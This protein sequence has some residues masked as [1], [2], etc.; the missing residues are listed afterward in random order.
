MK[1]IILYT[2]VEGQTRKIA[3][4]A[5]DFFEGRGWYVSIANVMDMLEFGLE[6]PDAAILLAPV[7]LARY[8]TPFSH[9]VHQEKD[10]LNSIPTAFVSVSLSIVSE[11]KDERDEAIG[12]PATLLEQTGWAPV[13]VHNAAGALRLAEF[14]FFKRWMVRRLSKNTASCC[15]TDGDR[16]FTN[17]AALEVFLAAFAAQCGGVD[18]PTVEGNVAA[19]KAN[20]VL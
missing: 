15:D 19:D 12:Y 1:I 4:A 5:A 6:R 16:E 20:T 14:D 8:P 7:H 13:A 11:M 18:A 9:F 17:W 2:T 3:Q 10:W